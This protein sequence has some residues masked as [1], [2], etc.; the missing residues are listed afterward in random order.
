MLK[1]A[2]VGLTFCLMLGRK[3]GSDGKKW[4]VSLQMGEDDLGE[5]CSKLTGMPITR[6][7]C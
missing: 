1:I 5:C 4:G 3:V 7:A 2:G 6:G